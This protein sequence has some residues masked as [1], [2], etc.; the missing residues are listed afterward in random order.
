[1]TI[2]RL[3]KLV[4]STVVYWSI[5]KILL[6]MNI[7][8]LIK[9]VFTTDVLDFTAGV[10]D[11]TADVYWST[12]KIGNAYCSHLRARTVV[13]AGSVCASRKK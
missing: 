2:G 7:S 1:M 3:I 4:F 10:L 13:R 5:D 12:D 8:R 6:Q 11:F 9:L